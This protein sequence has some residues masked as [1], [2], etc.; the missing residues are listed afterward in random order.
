MMSGQPFTIHNSNIDANRN[1]V[2]IDPLPAGTSA[3]SARTR[4]PSKTRAGAMAQSARGRCRST[5]APATGCVRAGRRPDL[6]FEAFNITGE[7]NFANPTGD[8][9]STNFL[10]TTTLAGGGF[11]RQ[12][13]SARRFGFFG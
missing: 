8:L 3:E 10:L 5:C 7:P 11:P 6:F 2:L 1:G 4:S 12:F 13:R 9:R